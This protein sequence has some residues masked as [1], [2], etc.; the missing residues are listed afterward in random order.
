MKLS[1]VCVSLAVLFLG[2]I[3][4]SIPLEEDESTDVVSAETPGGIVSDGF[5]HVDECESHQVMEITINGV[6]VQLEVPA[7]C[8]ENPLPDMGDPADR[9]HPGDEKVNHENPVD[10]Q[11]FMNSDEDPSSYI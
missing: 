6:T 9:L 11:M 1:L 10:N 5:Y 3:S 2:C 4:D 8:D 7:L